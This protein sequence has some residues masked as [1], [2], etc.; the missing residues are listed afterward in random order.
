M[1]TY[2]LPE[3]LNAA[4]RQ[5]VTTPVDTPL[6]VMAGAGTGKTELIAQR[7]VW[8]FHQLAQE[9][10]ETPEQRILVVT[11]TDKAAS[12]MRSRI[13]GALPEA[14]PAPERLWIHTFH[15]ASMRLL[16]ELDGQTPA[17]VSQLSYRRQ[18]DALVNGLAE[19]ASH[20]VAD[21]QK[22]YL[23]DG[24]SPHCVSARALLDLKLDGLASVLQTLGPLIQQIKTAGLTPAEFLAQATS[25]L[26]QLTS[27]FAQLPR[28]NAATGAALETM[29][30]R[31]DMWHPLW[32][33]WA[34]PDWAPYP[35]D[36]EAT[37]AKQLEPVAFLKVWLIAT[38]QANKLYPYAASQED[39]EAQLA[40]W[41]QLQSQLVALVATV[42]ACVQA[43]LGDRLDFDDLLNTT[44]KQL[45][46]DAAFLQAVQT[47]FAAVVVDEF[48]DS[49]AA[50]LGWLRALLALRD[51]YPLTVVG[52]YRQSIYGF[53]QAQPENLDLAFGDW[54]PQRIPLVTNYRSHVAILAASNAFAH[55]WLQ[56]APSDA[57]QAGSNSSNSVPSQAEPVRWV[58][59]VANT[60]GKRKPSAA[61]LRP[62]EAD[63]VAADIARLHA[64]QPALP[65]NEIAVLTTN[66]KQC[67][68]V[69]TALQARGIPSVRLQTRSFWN[70]PAIQAAAAVIALLANPENKAAW[71]CLLQQHCDDAQLM[72]LF[73][74]C[75]P[76]T[77]PACLTTQSVCQVASTWPALLQAARQQLGRTP[78][79]TLW[80]SLYS[81]LVNTPAAAN[82]SL[83][84]RFRALLGL[85][86]A[87]QQ[88]ITAVDEDIVFLQTRPEITVE[89]LLRGVDTGDEAD[90]ADPQTLEQMAK[91]NAVQLLT[92]HS[93]KG[94]EFEAVYV[95][96]TDNW[97]P[98]QA[99]ESILVFE[100][101]FAPH[102]GFGL[103]VNRMAGQ[104]NPLMGFYKEAWKR[105]RALAERQRL[106]YVAITRAK[107]QL[108]VTR[109]EGAPAWTAAPTGDV[110]TETVLV[111]AQDDG[112]TDAESQA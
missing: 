74:E 45:Q 11:F 84:Q 6:R 41:H 101:Q 75:P 44:R 39:I 66:N 23:L 67:E 70:Q 93:A 52:D 64:G 25:Q 108:T 4:Q 34:S 87:E 82:T 32:K 38:K 48:Q 104:K 103:L 65:L 105:P 40:R 3:R 112:E 14:P 73:A 22:T 53:R 85:I 56:D 110:Y 96:A 55:Q 88:D 20:E 81:S 57:L 80:E 79:L 97:Q 94:L 71:V 19:L 83:L 10:V 5:A 43:R 89:T 102:P 58:T 59:L 35:D 91:Q 46:Q 98:L 9:G 60:E 16:S 21:I 12:D 18:V 31:V 111:T 78:V 37:E 69:E 106:F 61:S 28:Y 77:W 27:T 50:Q 17:L 72:R 107:S 7:F 24:L 42:Y 86:T 90:V 2:L 49:N 30:E 47:Q 99:K 33:P 100:P 36:A 8:L 1:S 29:A 15:Q 13:L 109:H 92:I 68:A 95:C 54:Q 76:G 63:W 26:E 62:A 51:T